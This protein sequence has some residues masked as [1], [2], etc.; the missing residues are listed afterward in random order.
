[1]QPRSEFVCDT[2]TSIYGTGYLFIGFEIL[3]VTECSKQGLIC[4]PQ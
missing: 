3:V 1:M 4:K 2:P